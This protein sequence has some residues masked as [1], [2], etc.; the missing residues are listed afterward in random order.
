MM[1]GEN[2]PFYGKSHT[3]ETKE[4]ISESLKKS[5]KFLSIFNDEYKKNMS[6]TLKGRIFSTEHKRKL[7]LKAIEKANE[8]LDNGYQIVPNFNKTSC[9]LFDRIMV[10]KNIHIQHAMNG[11]EYYIKELGY[12][13]DGYDEENNIVYEYDEEHHF[14]KNGNLQEKDIIRQQEIENLL[15]CKFIRIKK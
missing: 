15:K 8:R 3:D 11:G 9:E 14:D 13:V 2:N 5:E 7:R 12:W 6:E 1:T 4:K 10:E